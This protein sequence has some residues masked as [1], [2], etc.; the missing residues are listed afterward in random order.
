MPFELGVQVWKIM[1]FRW[2]PSSWNRPSLEPKAVGPSDGRFQA[3]DWKLHSRGWSSPKWHYWCRMHLWFRLL[4]RSASKVD[5]VTALP[6]PNPSRHKMADVLLWQR[7][8][9]NKMVAMRYY[10]NI[11]HLQQYSYRLNL[12][13]FTLEYLTQM[14]CLDLYFCTNKS[15]S[16]WISTK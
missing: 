1:L 3:E 13:F 2:R 4:G 11:L 14:A 8:D 6:S 5:D 12:F 7:Y 15:I 10:G 9:N 16:S